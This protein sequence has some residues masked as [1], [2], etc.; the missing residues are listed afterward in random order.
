[1]F[2]DPVVEQYRL[3][4]SESGYSGVFTLAYPSKSVCIALGFTS[5]KPLKLSQVK[6]LITHVKSKH[7]AT[8]VFYRDKHCIE[9]QRTIK[10]G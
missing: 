7:R 6:A 2:D 5:T 10:L 1:M 4:P 8:L 9:T 3:N